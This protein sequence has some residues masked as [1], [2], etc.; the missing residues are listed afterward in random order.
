MSHSVGN[1]HT[2]SQPNAP[3]ARESNWLE[4]WQARSPLVT[5]YIVYVT[6]PLTLISM[7]FGWDGSIAVIPIQVVEKVQLYR[8]PLSMVFQGGFFILLFVVLMV[9]LRGP[10]VE[11]QKG[12]LLFLLEIVIAMLVIFTSYTLICYFIGFIPHAF[13]RGF[14]YAPSQG[15]WPYFLV[16]ITMHCIENPNSHS[17][18][19][20]F[21]IPNRVFPFF[22]VGLM[23]LLSM[24]PLLDLALGIAYGYGMSYGLLKFL[25]PTASQISSWET[26]NGWAVKLG[27]VNK[28]GYVY[29]ATSD[30]PVNRRDEERLRMEAHWAGMTGIGS[31]FG[32]RTGRDQAAGAATSRD[33]S[34][35]HRGSDLASSGRVAFSGQGRALAGP[36]PSL[37]TSSGAASVPIPQ[38]VDPAEKRR[39]ALQA[40]EK[41]LQSEQA[42]SS[43]TEEK[44]LDAMRHGDSNDSTNFAQSAPKS[45]TGS[46]QV[47]TL[48]SGVKRNKDYFGVPSESE[49]ES[50]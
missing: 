1:I 28:M 23:S 15:L 10:L 8:L 33:H 2:P 27:M 12:S 47:V 44:A 42:A 37:S 49:E 24:F 39:L 9:A 31:L 48:T 46:S 6:I 22:I 19:C 38:S 29:A 35:P 3:P 45:S 11:F 41:R 34:V 18:F 17:R 50:P 4:E 20:C 14:R 7:L 5:R 26:G 43:G 25:Q 36:S 40:V 32:G 16:L 30:L 21:D 13:A